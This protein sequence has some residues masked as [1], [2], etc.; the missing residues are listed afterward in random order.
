MQGLLKDEI[1]KA[2]ITYPKVFD[3]R[4]QAG[5]KRLIA[6]SQIDFIPLRSNAHIRKLLLVQYF[7]QRK[8]E[9]VMGDIKEQKP[10]FLKLFLHESRICCSV[11]FPSSYDF[12][13]EQLLSIFNTLLPGI[14]DIPNSLYRWYHPE[15]A[16][17]YCYVELEKL[18]GRALTTAD[19]KH[20]EKALREQLL[21]I[22]PLTPA[23]FWP[24]NEEES[25]RQIQLLRKEMQNPRELPHISILFQEQTLTSL[26]FMVHYVRPKAESKA[27]KGLTQTPFDLF[28]RFQ[29]TLSHPFP[30]EIGAFSI[31]VPSSVFDVKGSI[32]LLYARRFISK[33]L[34][35]IF[36]P[37][38]DYNGGL[39]E[40]Q[41]YYFEF[42]RVNLCDKIP[43]FDLFAEKVFYALHPVEARLALSLDD[44]E[45]LL[46]AFSETLQNQQPVACAQKGTNVTVIKNPSGA[47]SLASFSEIDDQNEIHAYLTV[48]NA[49]YLCCIGENSRR[50]ILNLLATKQRTQKK[51]KKLDLSFQEGAPPSLNPHL[52]SS[53]M[54][55]RILSKLLFEGLMRL[56]R[57]GQPECAGALEYECLE[58]GLSY[59]FKLRSCYWSNGEKVT[60]IDYVTSWQRALREHISHPEQLFIIKN[61]RLFKEYKCD[62]KKLGIRA[63]NPQTLEIE[64]ERPDPRFLHKLAQPFFFPLF[65]SMREPKWFNGP[66][67]IR[68]RSQEGL[69][70][71]KNPYFWEKNNPFFEQIEIKW[72]NDVDKIY[73]LFQEGKTDWIGDPLSTLSTSLIEALE[74]Q[75]RLIKRKVNRR[76]SVHFNTQFYPLSSPSIRHALSLVIDRPLIAETIF[77]PSAPLKHPLY[78]ESEAVAL[79]DKG[80]K[81]LGLTK[82]T[83]PPLTFS[84]SHQTGR[85][86]LGLYLKNVWEK[87]LGITVHLQKNEWNLFRNKL[88][89]GEFEITATIHETLEEAPLEFLERFEG[90]SSW[91]FSQWKQP[92]YRDWLLKA[93][94]SHDPKVRYECIK[95]AETI[96]HEEAPF[97]PLFGCIHLF[98]HHPDLKDYFFD[99]EGCVD[100]CHARLEKEE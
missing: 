61:G 58:G 40:K 37:F 69:L 73:Q 71:E 45:N 18:R 4:L 67:L 62:G 75:G 15:Y 38:R 86:K 50:Q 28:W 32:N 36:G 65:G 3:T 74:N 92:A 42:I 54:R 96:L 41:Q 2:L 20:I 72:Q 57:N 59:I 81:E 84:Y 14:Q 24:Y 22:P 12:N 46:L 8:M 21:A 93:Q 70:L 76:F 100:F 80:L 88:E 83:F 26:E 52:S 7:L 49:D 29:K 99:P 35:T 19:L 30:I 97:T 53:D 23:L 25:F 95:N 56:N 44:A 10:L 31:K 27:G 9:K 64:L 6:N 48:G 89:K 94:E 85:E 77:P 11:I 1:R 79:F 98:A 55:C 78:Q 66:Y 39:F 82:E 47:E 91:N 60:A 87:K 5:L 34:E 17:Q 68:N 63:L 33:N 43:L 51:L 90:S 13:R 16:Y